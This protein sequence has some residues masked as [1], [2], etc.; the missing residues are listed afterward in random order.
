LA[1]T[2]DAD[3]AVVA[4]VDGLAP[5]DLRELA[6]A[7]RNTP[8]VRVAVLIGATPTGGVSLAAAVEPGTAV[9]ASALLRD[10]AKAVGG[11]GGGKGDVATAGG[12][13][14]SAID[15]AVGL[16]RKAVATLAGGSA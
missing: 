16:A 12:K 2:A 4:R 13:D 8:Q 3:G 15:E 10:P 1:A 9:E 11:G 7:V 5:G 14:P 6:V